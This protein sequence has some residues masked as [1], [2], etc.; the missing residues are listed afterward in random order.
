MYYDGTDGSREETGLAYSTDGAFWKAY[1]GNPTLRAS[2]SPAWDSN[3][4]VYGSIFRDALGFHYWYSGGVS[5]PSEGIGYAFS[6]DGKTWTKNSTP[7]FRTTDG[8]T[9]RNS[10]TYTPS[11]IDDGSGTLKMY[12]T[13][14]GVG[15]PKKICWATLSP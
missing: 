5:S 1:S 4:A 12:Y 13:A 3:D 8:T 9:Y 7:V 10:R 14:V 11:V 15:G 2:A 6:S